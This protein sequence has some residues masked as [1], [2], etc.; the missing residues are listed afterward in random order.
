M[1]PAEEDGANDEQPEAAVSLKACFSQGL[2]HLHQR[3]ELCDA[4]LI[5]GGK[6]FPCNRALL[7]SISPYFQAIFTSGFKESRDGEVLLEDMDP[8]V[9]QNLLGYLYSGELVFSPGSAEDLFIAASRLQLSPALTLI[10]SDLSFHSPRP[11]RFLMERISP[12]NCLRLYMLGHDHN[13]PALL[14][15]ALRY[16]GLHFGLLFEH[17]DFLQLD[18]RALTRLLSSDHLVVASEMDIFRAAQRWARAEPSKRLPMLETLLGCVRFPLL[19]QEEVAQVQ[20]ETEQ[21][22]QQL[23]VHWQDLDGAGRLQ[24]SGGL[25][26]GMYQE[27]IICIKVPRLRDILSVSEDMDCYME[28]LNPITGSRT[29]LPA[30]ELV[31][32]PGC[33]VLDHRVYISGGKHADGSYSCALHEYNSPADC[34]TQ[35]PAMSTPRSVHMFLTCKQKLFALSGW[36]DAGPLA[37]AESFDVAQQVWTSIASLPIILR[38]SASAP[39][40]N[41]LYLIGGDADSDEVVYKGILIYDTHLDTWAQV[42]LEFSL[43]GAVAVPMEAGICVIG[44]FFSRK[45]TQPYPNRR[46]SQLLPCTSKCFFMQEAGIVSKEVAIPPLPVPLAFAG[47]TFFQGKIYVIGGVCTSR[48]HDAIYHWQPGEAAW[49]QYPENLTS[50]GTIVRRVLKCVTLKVPTLKLR[51]LMQEASA[52]R[53]AVGLADPQISLEKNEKDHPPPSDLAPQRPS[54]G[55]EL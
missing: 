14:H 7:A 36:N 21:L 19:T 46:F 26:Q 39:Y 51:A 11:G 45:V 43:H 18:L 44:G 42:P 25:R 28:C 20:A 33:S 48:T 8:S 1:D 52:S 4:T 24:M 55:G 30:L 50:Q 47:A 6:R 16:L 10:S 40:K 2:K 23:E 49:T 3:P 53:V 29:K 13:Q 35:L 12:E 17:Q 54:S 15:G 32:L 31:A 38:F 34:W 27:K 5:A 37:S 9:L 22:G 41:K